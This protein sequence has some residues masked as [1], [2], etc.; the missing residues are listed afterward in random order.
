MYDHETSIIG[1]MSYWTWVMRLPRQRRM[2]QIRWALRWNHISKSA[3]SKL[4][5]IL[6][7]HL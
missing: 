1:D 4:N 6:D 7:A 5:E 2:N 3:A